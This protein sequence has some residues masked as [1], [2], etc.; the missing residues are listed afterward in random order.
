VVAD[1]AKVYARR[2][3]DGSWPTPDVVALGAIGPE[4]DHVDRPDGDRVRRDVGR[5]RTVPTSGTFEC[6]CLTYG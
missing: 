5:I 1:D 6:R 4:P 3:A 2:G